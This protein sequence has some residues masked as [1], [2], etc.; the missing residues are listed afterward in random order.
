MKKKASCRGLDVNVDE[1]DRLIDAAMREPLNEN[2]GRTLKTA[3]HAMAE[4]LVQRRNTEKTS[5]VLEPKTTTGTATT[6][7]GSSESRGTVAIRPLLLPVRKGS[8]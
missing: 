8:A 2:D 1:L 3:V 7:P 4:R 5:V 6:A